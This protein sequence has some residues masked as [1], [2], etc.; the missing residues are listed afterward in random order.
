MSQ[1]T[2]EN[3]DNEVWDS[4]SLCGLGNAHETNIFVSMALMSK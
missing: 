1:H 3:N 2:I 4:Q